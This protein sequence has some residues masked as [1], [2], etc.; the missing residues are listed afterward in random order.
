MSEKELKVL[1]GRL[2][3]L[4]RIVLAYHGTLD[5]EIIEKKIEKRNEFRKEL[6]TCFPAFI[7]RDQKEEEP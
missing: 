3:N 5:A 7:K 2:A 4:E 6:I 1:E